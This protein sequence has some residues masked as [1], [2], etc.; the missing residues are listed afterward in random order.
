MVEGEE[1]Y[2]Y[3][4]KQNDA[5]FP[6]FVTCFFILLILPMYQIHLQECS[7]ADVTKA[8]QKDAQ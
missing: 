8:R 7:R 6:F 5:A 1:K 2:V 4:L 3:I